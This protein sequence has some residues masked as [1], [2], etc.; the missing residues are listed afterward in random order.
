MT[1]LCDYVAPK[2]RLARPVSVLIV[3]SSCLLFMMA[4]PSAQ[5]QEAAAGTTMP[6][7]VLGVGDQLT[8]FNYAENSREECLIRPD[9]KISLPLVGEILAAGRDPST[10][11]RDIEAMLAKFQETPD[12]TVMV[13]QIHSYRIYLL[14]RVNTQ[15]MLE[16]VV[17]LTL[18]QA[19]SMAGGLNEF[20]SERVVIHRMGKDGQELI[21]VDYGKILKGREPG[22]NI[23]LRAG[24][25]VVAQ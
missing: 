6:V 8:V 3:F 14:G 2:G 5:A 20:A 21:E 12:V 15:R 1:W 16:S 9:G 23:L 22:K 24:D 10:L 4:G 13:R 11:E 18:L 17:P 19:I 7:F 25:I